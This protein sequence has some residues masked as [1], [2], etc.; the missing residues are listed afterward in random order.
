LAFTSFAR[1]QPAPEEGEAPPPPEPE[2]QEEEQPTTGVVEGTV[3]SPDLEAPLAGATVTIVG[4]KTSVTTDDTGR[5]EFQNIKPGDIRIRVELTGFEPVERTLK[6]TAG[7]TLTITVPLATMEAP[8]LNETIVVV[9]SRTP[10][11]NLDSPVP[12]D[13]LTA[14]ELGR[15]GRTETGR[16]LHSLAPSFISTPQT[17]ADGSDH[18]D[19]ASLRGLGPDQVLILVNGKRRHRSAL[20]HINGT[21]GRGTVGADLNAIATGSIKRVEILRDG[22]A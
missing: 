3:E 12:I 20:M 22:A 19:P 17:V 16:I 5:F 6:V 13:V 11:T 8:L 2:A 4:T 10:R 14:E 21:F 15:S 18:V 1:A 9:G 7:V